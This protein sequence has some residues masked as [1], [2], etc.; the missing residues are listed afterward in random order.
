MTSLSVLEY[1]GEEG[2]TLL[3]TT[4]ADKSVAIWKRP[5]NHSD[6]QL[7]QHEILAGEAVECCS[8]AFLP[9][10]TS[11]A[12]PT[13]LLALGGVGGDGS[14]RGS[15]ILLFIAKSHETG[16]KFE[17][18]LTLKGHEDW[19]RCLAFAMSDEGK[20][21]LASASQDRYIRLWMI[22][23]L[24]GDRVDA[25]RDC[26]DGWGSESGRDRS[27]ERRGRRSEIRVL[28]REGLE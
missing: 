22:E 28:V 10:L 13:P 4:S 11:H 18:V 27:R 5:N 1:P 21:L 9:T 6:W 19:V 2:K 7:I 25:M 26:V 20:L 17:H 14:C 24:L 8:L 12:P 3:V 23:E 15:Q 16:L